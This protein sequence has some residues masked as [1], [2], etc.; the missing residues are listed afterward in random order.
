MTYFFTTI[1]Q[2]CDPKVYREYLQGASA[3]SLPF[4]IQVGLV[5]RSVRVLLFL[6][7]FALSDEIPTG[8]KPWNV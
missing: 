5:R 2:P 3:L 7:R 1:M 6:I 4:A 8:G